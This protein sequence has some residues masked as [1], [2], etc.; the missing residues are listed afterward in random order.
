MLIHR[1]RFVDNGLYPDAAFYGA[2]QSALNHL[3]AYRRKPLFQRTVPL[4]TAGGTSGT[5]WRWYCRTGYGAKRIGVMATLGLDDRNLAVDPYITVTITAVGG[6]ALTSQAFHYGA[7]RVIATDAPDEYSVSTRY[8]ACAAN[9][10]YTGDVVFTDNVRV[11]SLLVFEDFSSTVDD[12]TDYFSLYAPGGGSPIYDSRIGQQL[13]GVGNLLRKNGGL[14]GDWVPVDGVAR[15]RTSA[16]YINLYDNSSATPPT[17]AS[18]GVTLV[19]T[20][21]NTASATTAPIKM[22]VYGSVA[23]GAGGTVVLRDTGGTDAATVTVTGAAGWY[24]ATGAISVGAGQKYDLMFCGDGANTV[25]VNA[26]SFF[27]VGT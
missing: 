21:R 23:A 8:V 7:S 5:A 19:T 26:V 24:T 2:A 6:A 12:A 13:Q 4:G 20:A 15:T 11:I 17:A 18:P 25:T 10:E 27:E 9:T 1:H 14:R 22:A 16:T 3:T